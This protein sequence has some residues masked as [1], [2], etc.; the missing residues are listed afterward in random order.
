M[1][2]AGERILVVDDDRTV[3]TYLKA[4][5]GQGGYRVFTAM[6]ALQ[7]PMVARQ[8]QPDLVVLDLAMPGG[9]GPAVLE[10]LRRMQGMMQIPSSCS[11][12]PKERVEQL[13][14]IGPDLLFVQKPGTPDEVLNAVRSLLGALREGRARVD[15]RSPGRLLHDACCPRPLYWLAAAALV[16]SSAPT[17]AEGRPPG[18]GTEQAHRLA[19]RVVVTASRSARPAEARVGAMPEPPPGPQRKA[20]A[21]EFRIR[22]CRPGAVA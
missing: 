4:V 19:R 17:W 14:P 21:R 5:L 20:L 11:G 6:D 18:P 8:S 2:M 22:G 9:G 12:L 3:L 15:Q 13:V 10:R 7:G 1:A 16:P